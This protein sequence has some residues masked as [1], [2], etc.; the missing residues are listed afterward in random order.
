MVQKA[1]E[2]GS[3][4]DGGWSRNDREPLYVVFS[5][6]HSIRI[7]RTYNWRPAPRILHGTDAGE[8]ALN[9][10]MVWSNLQDVLDKIGFQESGEPVKPVCFG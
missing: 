5:S 6:L 8:E 9:F 10:W 1:E 7:V 4:L 3:V 2:S